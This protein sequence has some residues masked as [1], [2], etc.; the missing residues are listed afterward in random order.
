MVNSETERRPYE[1]CGRV[2]CWA[3]YDKETGELIRI[4]DCMAANYINTPDPEQIELGER[5]AK[6]CPIKG[7][8]MFNGS[9][10][11]I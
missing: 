6:Q 3:I 9:I 5:L 4:T 10:L 2:G 8:N 1:E 7:N 11:S